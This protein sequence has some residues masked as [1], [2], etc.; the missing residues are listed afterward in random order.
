MRRV[1]LPSLAQ[2]SLK[3]HFKI[4]AFSGWPVQNLL[5]SRDSFV[6][7]VSTVSSIF[8]APVFLLKEE[9]ESLLLS[10]TVL[11]QLVVHSEWVISGYLLSVP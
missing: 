8:W 4:K 10:V 6:F 5:L 1:K 3:T 2:L 9:G 7:I 11:A